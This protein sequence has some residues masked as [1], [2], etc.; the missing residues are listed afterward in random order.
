[1]RNIYLCLHNGCIIVIFN[2][3]TNKNT[4]NVFVFASMIN[5]DRCHSLKQV[6]RV[7][8]ICKSVRSAETKT[9]QGLYTTEIDDVQ[10]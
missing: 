8:F 10:I 7:P 1:M 6:F 2:E 4:F 3:S 5:I 9:F